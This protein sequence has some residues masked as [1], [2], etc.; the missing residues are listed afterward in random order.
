MIAAHEGFTLIAFK[1]NAPVLPVATWGSE[2]VGKGFRFGF[3]R[4]VLHIRYGTL[5]RLAPSGTR[6]TR[7]DL[8]AATRLIM[9]TIAGMLPPQYRGVYADAVPSSTTSADAVPS[10]ATS[11]DAISAESESAP[12]A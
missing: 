10:S 6:Y 12:P 9:G 4:P 7:E 1:A 2:M 11:A 3:R 8:A 5:L